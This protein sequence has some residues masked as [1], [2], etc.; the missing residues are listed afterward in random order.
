MVLCIIF[1]LI[2]FQR[3]AELPF[4]VSVQLLSTYDKLAFVYIRTTE[5]EKCLPWEEKFRSAR[6]ISREHKHAAMPINDEF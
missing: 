5:Q 3:E 4:F 1:L 2:F 6:R